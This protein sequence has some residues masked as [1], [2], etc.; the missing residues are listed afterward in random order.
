MLEEFERAMP[1]TIRVAAIGLKNDKNSQESEDEGTILSVRL[2]AKS[3]AD[4]TQ[5]IAEMDKHKIFHV[6]PKSQTINPGSDDIGF[7]LEVAYT[8]VQHPEKDK[9]DKP[10]AEKKKKK[11]S[12]DD[13]AKGDDD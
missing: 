5:M 12:E 1:R 2:Y 3:E 9:K 7:D 10:A 4:V 13:L 8:P 6:E 11:A